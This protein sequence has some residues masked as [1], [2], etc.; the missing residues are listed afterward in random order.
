MDGEK[1]TKLTE[2]YSSKNR[3]VL[4]SAKRYFVRLI[5]RLATAMRVVTEE[6]RL[7]YLANKAEYEQALAKPRS[8]DGVRLSKKNINLLTKEPWRYY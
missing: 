5:L 7:R 2:A 4:A 8:R 3:V 1:K 6:F